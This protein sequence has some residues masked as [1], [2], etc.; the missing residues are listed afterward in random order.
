[1]GSGMGLLI[2]KPILEEITNLIQNNGYSSDYYRVAEMLNA[3]VPWPALKAAFLDLKLTSSI[4]R[5]LYDTASECPK[6]QT[7]LAICSSYLDV[8]SVLLDPNVCMDPF[9]KQESR[10]LMDC[11]GPSELGVMVA[12]LFAHLH[13]FSGLQEK[14]LQLLKDAA[15]MPDG[16]A[17]LIRGMLRWRKA[18]APQDATFDSSA[19]GLVQWAI[20]QLEEY[21]LQSSKPVV[22]Y[23][24]DLSLA[25]VHSREMLSAERVPAPSRFKALVQKAQTSDSQS[26]FSQQCPEPSVEIFWKF[27][28]AFPP[29]Q[30]KKNWE[31]WNC[32]AFESTSP[33]QFYS[34]QSFL[35]APSRPREVFFNSPIC[36]PLSEEADGGSVGMSVATKSQSDLPPVVALPRRGQE[37]RRLK[38]GAGSSRP[39]SIH[40]DEY[41]KNTEEES[42]QPK[43]SA[44]PD[45]PQTA[46]GFLASL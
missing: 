46:V 20:Q 1:M 2:V 41:H 12:V 34:D 23:L 31:K 14:I 28:N 24:K 37:S 44:D 19:E 25:G 35:T 39:P 11:P 15:S 17:I 26:E 13:H 40:V 5:L 38:T 16:L 43:S 30:L 9:E 7:L 32:A 18:N 4:S 8:F 42:Y 45:T 3:L 6:D 27:V 33:V 29:Y 22:E 36:R 21:S 10:L